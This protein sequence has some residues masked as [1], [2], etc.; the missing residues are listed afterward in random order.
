M[1]ERG[2]SVVVGMSGGVDS[3]VAAGLLVRDGLRVVGVTMRLWTGDADHEVS[4]GCCSL[5]G[6]Q[7]ARETCAQLGIP[8][9]VI[10]LS[11]AFARDVV[12]PFVAGYATGITPNPCTLCNARVRFDALLRIADEL[13]C[14]SVATGHYARTRSDPHTGRVELLA[15]VCKPKDQSYML[16]GLGQHHLRRTLF[17]LGDIPSKEHTRQIAADMGLS[18]ARRTDSQDVCFVGAE[19]YAAFVGRRMETIVRPGP[20][21]DDFGRTIGTHS[22]I[23]GY[24]VGQ[25]RRLPASSRGPLFVVR[26][27]PENNAVHVGPEPHLYASGL[28]ARD[29]NWV[30]IE[31]PVEQ[32]V[33]QARIRYNASLVAATVV[34]RDDAAR[35]RFDV[36][37]RA[38]A[39]GQAVVFYDKERVLGGG[40]IVEAVR[41][42]CAP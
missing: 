7:D 30:S 3:A 5:A 38:V 37:Q 18:I 27:D 42:E 13:G 39:P 29:L 4:R 24:T 1:A 6:V 21:I 41:K 8:H 23:V 36:P 32:L 35:C 11:D 33:V 28:I 40:T 2:T 9:Y 31:P 22:G 10:D 15:A 16:Y 26:L 20:I 34:V 17:P 19:G 14:Q 25:R 12:N